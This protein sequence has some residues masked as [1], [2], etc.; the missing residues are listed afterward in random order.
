MI[1]KIKKFFFVKDITPVKF[2]THKKL[3]QE[4]DFLF[5]ENKKEVN[6]KTLSS[7]AEFFNHSGFREYKEFI[8]TDPYKM[9]DDSNKGIEDINR[10]ILVIKDMFTEIDKSLNK[11]KINL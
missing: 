8:K 6:N 1:N 9:I 7:K 5:P 10:K 3:I 4:M 11:V 2:N